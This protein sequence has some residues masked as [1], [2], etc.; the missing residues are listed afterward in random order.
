MRAFWFDMPINFIATCY[1]EAETEEEAR[2]KLEQGEWELEQE[3]KYMYLYG[4]AKLIDSEDL[5]KSRYEQCKD[6]SQDS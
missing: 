4:D 3:T 1:V 2:N 6:I 5:E